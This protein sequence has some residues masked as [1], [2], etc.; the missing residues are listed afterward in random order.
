MRILKI[1][2]LP[3]SKHW[4]DRDEIML[5]SCFQI[6]KDCVEKEH[7]D[8]HCNYEAHKEFVDE[9]RFLYDW[10]NERVKKEIS[11]DSSDEMKEDD[12]MLIRLMKIRTSLWT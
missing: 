11:P 9:V 7:V 3:N 4:V 5:H 1:E 12:E 8:T 6:L 2:S 10:W